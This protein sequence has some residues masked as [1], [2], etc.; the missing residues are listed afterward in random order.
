MPDGVSEPP[1]L[2]PLEAGGAWRDVT[3]ADLPEHYSLGDAINVMRAVGLEVRLQ[4][5]PRG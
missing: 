3:I 5:R 2:R 4:V 1:V